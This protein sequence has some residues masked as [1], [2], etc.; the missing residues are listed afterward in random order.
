MYSVLKPNTLRRPTFFETCK[1]G[2]NNHKENF[3]GELYFLKI[4]V[5][6]FLNGASDSIHQNINTF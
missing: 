5:K 4:F 2:E 3:L 6:D 1:F